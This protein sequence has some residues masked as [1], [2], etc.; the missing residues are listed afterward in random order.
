MKNLVMRF[1]I[2]FIALFFAQSTCFGSSSDGSLKKTWIDRSLSDSI[3]FDAINQYYIKNTFNIPDSSWILAQYHFDLAKSVDSK[4]QMARAYN[5]MAITR[6]INGEVDSAMFFLENAV[7]LRV[8]MRDS[9]GIARLNVNI[10]NIY[11]EKDNF[12]QAV[13]YFISSQVIFLELEEFELLADVVNNIGLLYDDLNMEDLASDYFFKAMNYYEKIGLDDTNGNIWFNIGSNYLQKNQLDSALL[14]FDKSYS[15][16]KAV[17]NKISLADYYH[18]MA[19]LKKADGDF[20]SALSLIDSSLFFGTE[21]S[22]QRIIN[23]GKLLKAE[24]IGSSNPEI[25]ISL[26]HS[27]LD[28]S[29]HSPSYSVKSDAYKLLHKFYKKQNSIPKALAMHENYILYYDS[30][31]LNE[32]KL[33]M[34]R[35]VLISQHEKELFDTQLHNQK[36]QDLFKIRQT[37]QFYW[38]LISTL[39]FSIL[40][41]FFARYRLNKHQRERLLLIDKIEKLK[42]ESRLSLPISIKSVVLNRVKVEA[43]LYRKLNKTDWNIL[44]ILLENPVASN[45][46]LSDQASLSLEGVSSSLRRMYIEFDV[47]SSKYMKIALILEIIRKSN[48]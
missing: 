7:K 38:V 44:T 42:G 29:K 18:C 25:A 40:V 41:L 10:G 31:L 19:L 48:S 16:F 13:Q 6:Y 35:G 14:Y 4:D 47:K 36:A 21:V 28:L 27:V 20:T 46:D 45:K 9:L 12:Q 39:V 30:V 2:L 24:L 43:N 17:N 33:A 23:S 8:L 26:V 32:N 22:N 34:V 5:E 15:L 3:R 37:H 11:R 1:P